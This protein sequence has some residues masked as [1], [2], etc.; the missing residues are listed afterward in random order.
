LLLEWICSRISVEE[1][2]VGYWYAICSQ[3]CRLGHNAIF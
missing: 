2:E 3:E 1:A